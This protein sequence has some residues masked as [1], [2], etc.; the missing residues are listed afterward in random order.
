[1]SLPNRLKQRIRT[2]ARNVTPMCSTLPGS[3]CLLGI[4]K[5][6]RNSC[7]FV[8]YYRP[9]KIV[10]CHP[11]TVD[12]QI[13]WKFLRDLNEGHRYTTPNAFLE[14]LNRGVAGSEGSVLNRHYILIPE[15]SKQLDLRKGEDHKITRSV[16]FLP[17][18]AHFS[19]SVAAIAFEGQSNYFHWMFD[20][21]PQLHLLEKSQLAPQCLYLECHTPFQKQSLE[22]LGYGQKTII[23]SRRY[24]FISADRLV[25]PSFPGKSGYVTSWACNYL[26]DR[27]LPLSCQANLP[28][29]DKSYERV[30]LSRKNAARR[31]IT[32]EKEL[33]SFLSSKG[34]LEIQTDQMSLLDQIRLFEN[35]KI[36]VSP[37]G[38]GLTNLVFCRQ[39]T[40]VIELFSP[41]YVNGCYWT[42]CEQIG[43]DYYYL[44]GEG[45][46]FQSSQS[47]SRVV[48][49]VTDDIEIDIRKLDRLFTLAEI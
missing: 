27:F 32:N 46:A 43:L 9:E 29:D 33:E 14:C 49:N 23:D 16:N 1:M 36:V 21:L 26:R 17:K 24:K 35:A 44:M 20:A 42:L 13:H 11:R 15:L 6:R 12:G 45:E 37:H 31:R 47:C 28:F 38:A 8:P 19:S 34:F 5:K 10:R 41:Q 30:Y 7:D 3:F 25:V 39:G 48:D 40:K 2:T 4:P 22:I 18:V